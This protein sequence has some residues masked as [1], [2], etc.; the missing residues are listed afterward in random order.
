MLVILHAFKSLDEAAWCEKQTKLPF[1]KLA[2]V[3]WCPWRSQWAETDKKS[4]S[5]LYEQPWHS[6]R[7]TLRCDYFRA[8]Y[9]SAPPSL[10]I[11]KQPNPS[12]GAATCWSDTGSEL[13]QDTAAS[14]RRVRQTLFTAGIFH[15]FATPAEFWIDLSMPADSLSEAEIHV[16]LTTAL[17]GI[18]LVAVL[19]LL[20]FFTCRLAGSLPL[21]GPGTF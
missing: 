20:C 4:Q 5:C 6:T 14:Q 9:L 13:L 19:A 1:C 11:I 21:G 15:P 16:I 18:L 10:S 7:H 3:L 8:L 2:T 17:T 12:R